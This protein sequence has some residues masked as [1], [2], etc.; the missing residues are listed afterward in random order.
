MSCIDAFS[1]T[2]SLSAVSGAF[3]QFNSTRLS[4][5]RLE[6]SDTDCW[7][8]L[9]SELCAFN[10]ITSYNRVVQPTRAAGVKE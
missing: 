3:L 6:A 4:G 1:Y 9:E 8:E 5:S 2:H 10:L 7:G